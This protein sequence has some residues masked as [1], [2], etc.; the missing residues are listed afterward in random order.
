[1]SIGGKVFHRSRL[2]ARLSGRC[3]PRASMRPNSGAD[4]WCTVA[5]DW[6]KRRKRHDGI[7]SSQLHSRIGPH[8]ATAVGDC[9]SSPRCCIRGLLNAVALESP[10]QSGGPMAGGILVTVKTNNPVAYLIGILAFLVGGIVLAILAFSQA[11]PGGSGLGTIGIL[12]AVGAVV[13][14]IEY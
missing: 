7:F 2:C 5:I 3:S 10:R 14:L 11:I 6:L 8:R 1:M 4:L 9:D 12:L 13:L